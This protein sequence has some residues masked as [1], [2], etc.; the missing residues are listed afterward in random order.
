VIGSRVATDVLSA[1]IPIPGRG[2]LLGEETWD[3]QE[4]WPRSH[5][6]D[7]GRDPPLV[8]AFLIG[9]P[10]PK[11][12]WDTDPC[13]HRHVSYP[14]PHGKN[15]WKSRSKNQ[16]ESEKVAEIFMRRSRE[17]IVTRYTKG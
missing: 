6:R 3:R 15:V 14:T 9:L 2:A 7:D 5:K 10:F 1:T 4:P 8:A 11:S 13:L 12:K 17:K 16:Q